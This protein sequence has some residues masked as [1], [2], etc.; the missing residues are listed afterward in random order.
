MRVLT[1]LLSG[2]VLVLFPW[3]LTA[4]SA[5]AAHPE[6]VS[7]DVTNLGFIEEISKFRSG[8]GHDF[9]YDATFP[10]GSTDSTEPPSS[11][12]H[13]FAPYEKHNGDQSTVPVYAPVAGQITRVTNEGSGSAVNKRVEIESSVD[14]NYTLVLFHIDLGTDYP[15]ILND[16]PAEFWPDH[17]EDDT[18]YST[19]IV[20]P[21]DLLGYADMRDS[22]DFDV[23]VLFED[24]DGSRYW[25]SYF[26]IMPDSVFSAYTTRGVERS[27]LTISKADRFLVPVDWWGGRNDEDWVTLAEPVPLDS[28][29]APV[30]ASLLGLFGIA[31]LF[32]RPSLVAVVTGVFPSSRDVPNH[33]EK[34][35]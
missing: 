14:P 8:A 3:L 28:W 26:D 15:Q 9:S 2:A 10:F 32:R 29:M 23:A 22:H 35:V 30:M 19:V 34:D 20:T 16:W 18:D 12:K 1:Q 21:G 13:Y 6:L 11:M 33:L 24:T 27:Q 7:R 31:M 17:Q 5:D 4:D 25:I